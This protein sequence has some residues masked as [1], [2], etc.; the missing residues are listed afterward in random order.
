MRVRS[1]EITEDEE[2][3]FDSEEWATDPA[4]SW[5]RRLLEL[6]KKLTSLRR[7]EG[8]RGGVTAPEEHSQV[9]LK[10]AHDTMMLAGACSERAIEGYLSQSLLE[11][12]RTHHPAVTEF[13]NVVGSSRVATR[14]YK[15][16]MKSL[17]VMSSVSLGCG[18]VLEFSEKV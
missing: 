13:I 12:H 2:R 11:H 17:G 7:G 6:S 18:V 4:W 15:K 8:A 5:A 10:M 9:L 1:P 16:Y 3:E 14:I